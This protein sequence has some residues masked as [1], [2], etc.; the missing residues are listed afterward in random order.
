MSFLVKDA[1]ES[2]PP[3][4]AMPI[5]PALAAVGSHREK[6]LSLGE[7]RAFKEKMFALVH[8]QLQ[9]NQWRNNPLGKAAVQKEWDKLE[10]LKAWSTHEVF[11]LDDLRP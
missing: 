8:Q 7:A 9:P 2:L 11:E 4:P 10:R 1:K 5:Q 6:V 3:A